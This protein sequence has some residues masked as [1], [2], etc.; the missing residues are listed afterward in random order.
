[1]AEKYDPLESCGKDVVFDVDSDP[2]SFANFM[3]LYRMQPPSQM[4]KMT[5]PPDYVHSR[6]GAHWF[7]CDRSQ[8]IAGRS[9]DACGVGQDAGNLSARL[10]NPPILK[11][12]GFVL[13][14]A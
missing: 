12:W 8:N 2:R 11:L 6:E 14:L 4:L 10:P 7:N 3:H 5:L 13:V 1:M 9:V